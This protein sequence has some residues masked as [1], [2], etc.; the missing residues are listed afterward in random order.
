MLEQQEP[1]VTAA[2]NDFDRFVLENKPVS[3]RD[4]AEPIDPQT[5]GFG[6]APQR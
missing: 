1:I 3:I 4:L 6:D 2:S 5:L